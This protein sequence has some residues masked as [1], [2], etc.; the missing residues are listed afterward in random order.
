MAIVQDLLYI[1]KS[2]KYNFLVKWLKDFLSKKSSKLLNLYKKYIKKVEK[3]LVVLAKRYT[4]L[5][6]SF[7]IFA[8]L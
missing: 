6:R 7:V 2:I 4:R 1:K 5:G 3:K 8:I